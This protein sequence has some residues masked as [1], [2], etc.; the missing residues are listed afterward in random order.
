MVFQ[1]M[2]GLFLLFSLHRFFTW[3]IL[4]HGEIYFIEQFFSWKVTGGV[5]MSL[6]LCA[7]KSMADGLLCTGLHLQ[8]CL[9]HHDHKKIRTLLSGAHLFSLMRA[10]LQCLI[11]K[12]FLLLLFIDHLLATTVRHLLAG[13]ALLSLL[14]RASW[15]ISLDLDFSCSFDCT[16][17]SDYSKICT[18]LAWALLSLLRERCGLYP[19]TWTPP[20]VSTDHLSSTTVWRIPF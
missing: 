20:P 2:P 18:L 6:F 9:R 3:K 1:Y 16:F 8:S 5:G 14:M 17:L 12:F 4:F 7:D 19:W 13:W 10:L 11:I 15:A